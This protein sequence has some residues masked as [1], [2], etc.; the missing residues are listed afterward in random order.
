MA[1]NKQ[2][3]FK[4][5]RIFV[6]NCA[7][8]NKNIYMILNCLRLIHSRELH[9]ITIEFMVSGHSFLPCD[10]AFG[11][12]EN[13][14]KREPSINCPS[15]YQEIIEKATAKGFKVFKMTTN[16]FVDIKSLLQHITLRIP[17]QPIQFSKGRTFTLKSDKPWVYHVQTALGNQDVNLMKGKKGPPSKRK[18]SARNQP[19]P[20]PQLLHEIPLNHKYSGLLKLPDGKME[21][22]MALREFV[23]DNGKIW[24]DE[25]AAQQALASDIAEV[26]DEHEACTDPENAACNDA[27]EDDSRSEP[28]DMDPPPQ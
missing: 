15:E 11:N 23:L 3:G 27:L 22:L 2:D 8:Q 19:S 26:Y 5:L 17:V 20:A 13:K 24:L 10:R 25:L 9:E 18:T 12:I 28:T 14:I 7:G 1:V 16:D 6:D 4:K 21:D